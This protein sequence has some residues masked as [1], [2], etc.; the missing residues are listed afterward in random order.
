MSH[1]ND[2][3]QKNEINTLT[4]DLK[5]METM[6]EL[7]ESTIIITLLPNKRLRHGANLSLSE[8][9]STMVAYYSSTKNLAS[10][11]IGGVAEGA[12]TFSRGR[13]SAFIFEQVGEKISHDK[14]CKIFD[15][16]L[17]RFTFSKNSPSN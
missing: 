4:C 9:P 10:E 15:H 1:Q 14:T 17:E 8:E 5:E 13:I 16:N 6:C 3:R 2:R 7:G 11:L 12:P